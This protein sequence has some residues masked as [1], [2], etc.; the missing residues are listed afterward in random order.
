[1]S[2]EITKGILESILDDSSAGWLFNKLTISTSD[3]SNE[4]MMHFRSSTSWFS[5]IWRGATPLFSL[6]KY[7]Y[8][9]K[10]LSHFFKT[11]IFGAI[12]TDFSQ[13]IEARE[14]NQFLS[15]RSKFFFDK[16]SNLFLNDCT[17]GGRL[18]DFRFRS[19]NRGSHL[20]LSWVS[21]L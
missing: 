21:W 11:E 6:W 3:R 7:F 10:N 9:P 15:Q 13:K 20:R 5:T 2:L 19:K 8:S 12:L 1:M 4:E 16:E 14:N 18:L 17:E